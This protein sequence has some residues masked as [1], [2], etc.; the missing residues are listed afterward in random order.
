MPK[1]I[2]C[3]VHELL[4]FAH[5]RDHLVIRFSS[6]INYLVDFLLTARVCWGKHQVVANLTVHCSA[7]RVQRNSAAA[8]LFQEPGRIQS[9][10]RAHGLWLLLWSLAPLKREYSLQTNPALRRPFLLCEVHRSWRATPSSSK[11]K[12]SSS[13]H[14]ILAGVVL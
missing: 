11:Q 13:R 3:S 6:S 5:L 9:P 12:W 8:F 2:R 7:S 1:A 4:L 14:D 10:R